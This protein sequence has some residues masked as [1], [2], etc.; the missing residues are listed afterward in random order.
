MII[1]AHVHIERKDD[2]SFYTPREIVEAMDS[3]GVDVSVVF[4]NDQGDA[5]IRPPW[6]KDEIAVATEFSDEAVAAFCAEFPDRLI[7]VSSVYPG[8]YRPEKK[9]R[10][11]IEEFGLRGVKLYPHA[12]FYAN[13]RR[14]YPV[15]DYCQEAKV[16]V[17]IHTGIKALRRQYMKY[18]CPIYVDD[19]AADFPELDIVMCHGGYPWTEEFFAVVSANP[20][21]WVDLTFLD[22]I[23]KKFVLPGLVENTVRR[24]IPVI[25]VSRL[26]WG[27]EGPFMNLPLYGSHGPENYKQSQE[28]LVRRFDFLSKEDKENILG[29][30][31]KRLF[32]K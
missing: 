15:Y 25:G 31:A 13:D 9:I 24:L 20:N 8:R 14:L 26:L 12:G 22:Y 3:G 4:G 18:N 28:I 23:E 17:I 5:G 19:V 6:A 11:A 32:M 7:G 16:P 27:T 30:N 10:R 1:D 2:G 29:E 21:T